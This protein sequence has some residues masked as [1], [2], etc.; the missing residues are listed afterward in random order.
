MTQKKISQKALLKIE[1]Y[2]QCD[3]QSQCENGLLQYCLGA[4]L[5]C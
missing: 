2:C 4:I 1:V 3:K 5:Y